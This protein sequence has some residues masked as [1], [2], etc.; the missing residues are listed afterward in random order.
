VH[1]VP[2]RRRQPALHRHAFALY[3]IK[4]VL[5]TVLSRLELSLPADSD[6]RPVRRAI[7]LAPSDGTRVV[8][9]A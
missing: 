3:E 2:V 1:L 7:T 4:V 6:V 5:A 8:C 9:A